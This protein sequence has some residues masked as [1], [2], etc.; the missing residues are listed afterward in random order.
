MLY[1]K[2]RNNKKFLKY[3]IILYYMIHINRA[4][5]IFIIFNVDNVSEKLYNSISLSYF[6]NDDIQ[7][8]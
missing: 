7:T 5:M 3:F 8:R 2:K 6:H 4:T 1:P